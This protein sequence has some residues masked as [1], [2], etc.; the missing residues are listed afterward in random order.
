MRYFWILLAICLAPGQ[1][2]SS[3]DTTSFT[4]DNTAFYEGE[5]LTY[6]VY[7][8]GDFKMVIDEASDEGY[9]FAFIPPEAEYGSAEVLVG[10]NIY[11]I[12]GMS[13]DDAL[14][15][16]TAGLREHYGEDV[17]ILPVDSVFSGSGEVIP[18]FYIDDKKAFIPNVMISYYDG[19]SEMLIFELVIS[20]TALR[21]KAEEVFVDCLERFKALPIGDLG[22][23]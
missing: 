8:P 3:E 20:P 2:V 5:K 16:D 13:F 14:T 19:V 17:L 23:E 18:T 7:P 1:A 15:R 4:S 21:F 9:S 12:R 11:K 10:V 6:V 22:Y